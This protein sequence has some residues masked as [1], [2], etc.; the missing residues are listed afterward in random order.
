MSGDDF[1]PLAIA[2]SS[3]LRLVRQYNSLHLILFVLQ[4]DPWASMEEAEEQGGCVG[5]GWMCWSTVIL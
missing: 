2:P 5:T 3:A 4:A 1:I